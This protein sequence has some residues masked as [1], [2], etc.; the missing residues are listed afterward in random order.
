MTTKTNIKAGGVRRNHNETMKGITI[1]TR[2]KAGARTKLAVNHN[3]AMKGVAVK[4]QVK[5]GG[6]N[7]NHNESMR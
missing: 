6:H 1:K 5:A 7:L 4:T 3:E 2:V